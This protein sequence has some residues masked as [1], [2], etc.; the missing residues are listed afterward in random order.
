MSATWVTGRIRK[1]G[2]RPY[3]RGGLRLG[4]FTTPTGEARA[5][6]TGRSNV[7]R[8]SVE[9]APYASVDYRAKL[10]AHRVRRSMSCKGACWDSEYTGVCHKAAA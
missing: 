8:R 2:K 3:R 5:S 4:F 6:S 7:L 1:R 10:R 9:V